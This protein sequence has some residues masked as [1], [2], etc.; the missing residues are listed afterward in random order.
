[1]ADSILRLKVESQEYDAKIKRA[2][3]GLRR[4]V[5]VCHQQGDVIG[6]LLGDTRKYVDSIGQMETV[7]KTAR[8]SVNELKSAFTEF[9]HVYNQ[10]SDEEKKGDFGKQL[11]SQLEQL[12]VRIRDGENELKSINNE[13]SGGG[14]L[15]DAL[16]QV[17]GKFGL[18]IDMVTKFGG[19][20]GVTT[21]ALKVAKDAFF[22]SESNIDEWNRTVKGAEGAYDIFL[23]TLNNGNWSNFFS[24]LSQAITGARDLYDAFDRL[25]SIKANNAVAIATTQAEIQQLHLLKQQGQDVDDKIK[26]ATQRLSA[27]QSQSANAGIN[28]GRSQVTNTLR[29]G[30]NSIGGAYINDATL[31]RVADN[32]SKQGQAYF[33]YMKRRAAALE[34]Q[35]MVTKT[36][37]IM[38]SQGGTYERQHKAFDINALSKE[39]QKQYAIAKTV[40]ERETEIQKGLTVWSQSVNEQA[41]NAREQ[42]RDNRYALQGSGGG[43]GRGSGRGGTTTI[44]PSE[45]AGKYIEK[46]Q[47]DYADAISNAQ[48]KLVENMM[49]SDEYDKQILSGQ[50]KLADAYLKAYNETGDEK[51]L[52]AFRETATHVKEMQGVVDANAEAQKAAEQA[53]RE[54]EA[55]QKKLADAENRLAEAQATGSATAI[56][57][58]Q[59]AVNKQRD[60]L[61][62]MKNGTPEPAKPTGLEAMKQTIQA[63]LKFDQMKVD[64]TTLHT[65]LNTAIQNGLDHIT[66]DYTGLQKRIAQGIDIPNST[67]E[68]LQN[69]INENLKKLGVEPIKINFET[70]GI[71]N[72]KKGADA[73]SKSMNQAASAISSVGSALQQIEDPTAKVMGIVAQAIA[74]IALSFADALGEDRSTKSNIWAFIGASAASMGAMIS[75]ISQIH[76][77]T[78][79]AEGGLIK[80]NSY[81]GDNILMPV[82]GGAGGY[83]GL[84]AGEIVLNKAAQGNL[85]SQLQGVGGSMNLRGIIRGEDILVVAD[86]SAR[87]QG[88][89]ELL[90]WK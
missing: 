78:G 12:K 90:F 86:R 63:E 87:R 29:N 83:A 23:Q 49:K 50:Q 3:E 88:K 57:Q 7:N 69:E 46:A 73:T 11:N 15:K 16:D 38:D 68:S 13:I 52:S 9:R 36:E 32:I 47:K 60:V 44:S 20:V 53:A 74:T 72:V 70:G 30:V 31:N 76:S 61:D 65:L 17:A 85:A 75:A 66:P 41:S 40:T 33:D 45:Q 80:G 2:A 25:N 19:V 58:A 14:G 22:Q 34:K 1:M 5:D 28:A 18:N 48:Q 37:T 51:Y 84:N 26:A 55:A 43:G 77:A 24:N 6:R 62:R 67:W 27:L 54:L 42:F 64:E 79:Y 10:L 8:G 21:T 82:D 71:E 81:S 39:Q 59:Q 35:G 4:Y 56:Y 89:G